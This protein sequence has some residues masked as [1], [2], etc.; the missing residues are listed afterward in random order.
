M[1]QHDVSILSTISSPRDQ[2]SSHHSHMLDNSS[3]GHGVQQ[4]QQQQSSSG[5]NDNMAPYNMSLN[6]I[7]SAMN[8]KFKLP[9]T[10]Q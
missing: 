8:P 6:L 3:S 2:S 1:M 4:Q 9:P 7:A 5:S 10:F